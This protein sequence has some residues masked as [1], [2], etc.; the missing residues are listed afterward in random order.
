[1]AEPRDNI[2]VGTASCASLYSGDAARLSATFKNAEGDLTTPDTVIIVVIDP[3]LRAGL[4]TGAAI[5]EDSE[6]ELHADWTPTQSGRHTVWWIGAGGVDAQARETFEVLLGQRLIE[7]PGLP[8]VPDEILSYDLATDKIIIHGSDLELDENAGIIIGDSDGMILRSVLGRFVPSLLTLDHVGG[9][10]SALAAKASVASLSAEQAARAAADSELEDAIDTKQ[11]LSTALTRRA[12]VVRDPGLCPT[13]ALANY[14]ETAESAVSGVFHAVGHGDST[15]SHSANAW[16]YLLAQRVAAA[17]PHIRTVYRYWD[18]L[19]AKWTQP[20]VLQAASG[21]RRMVIGTPADPANEGF[22]ILAGADVGQLGAT[23]GLVVDVDVAP[24]SWTP[25]GERCLASRMEGG[26][27]EGQRQFQFVTGAGVGNA[28]LRMY[29]YPTGTLSGALA[30]TADAPTPFIGSQ[31]GMVRATVTSAAGTW[32][33]RFFTSS[34]GGAT[35]T[36]LGN[37]QTRSHAN[38]IQPATTIPVQI[39]SSSGN[40]LLGA[41]FY[42]VAI[43][44]SVGNRRLNPPALQGVQLAAGKDVAWQGSP[45]FFVHN[46]G[47]SGTK[48]S[49][50]VPEQI[51]PFGL[52]QAFLCHGHNHVEDAGGFWT[53]SLVSANGS[54]ASYSAMRQAVPY[55]PLTVVIQN[56]HQGSEVASIRHKARQVAA[57][58]WAQREGHAVFSVMD[59]FQDLGMNPT[60]FADSIHPSPAGNIAIEQR[61]WALTQLQMGVG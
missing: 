58:A 54:L 30:V 41:T 6:G 32:T 45:T 39:G 60:L 10:V 47:S 40:R 59:L 18:K 44:G 34:D 61:L 52:G 3:A 8:E 27:F 5:V 55:G 48:I 7:I 23:E 14:L 56:M 35:W 49:D 15:L 37:T 16:M 13:G 20:E 21:E 50:I 29:A 22:G 28:F 26:A 12:A 4:I 53:N 43:R 46:G 11:P 9:L 36:Q 2:T 31:R 24:A 57:R 1:M 19:A 38:P 33:F 25:P 17:Y 51:V 42:D